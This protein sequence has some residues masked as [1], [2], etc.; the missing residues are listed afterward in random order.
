ME[1]QALCPQAAAGAGGRAHR[2]TQ[3]VVLSVLLQ[4]QPSLLLQEG[5]SLFLS[6]RKL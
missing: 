3:E 1:Q 2:Q 4:E 6:D 5:R